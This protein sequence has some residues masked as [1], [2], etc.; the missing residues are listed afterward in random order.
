MTVKIVIDAGHG[1]NTPGKRTPDG[2]MREWEFNAAT[3]EHVKRL[4]SKYEGVQVLFTHD[5]TG[6]VDVSLKARTDKANRWGADAFVSIHANA[7]GSGTE[8]TNAHGIETYIHPNASATSKALAQKIQ[9]AMIRFTGRKDRGVR[10]ANFQVLRETKMPAVLVECGFMT[11]KEEA[12]LLKDEGYRA[13][14]ASAIVEALVAQ[15]K[16]KPKQAPAATKPTTTTKPTTPTKP[17]GN[18]LFK[19][20]VGAFANRDNA[21]R[22]KKELESKGYEVIIVEEVR[23]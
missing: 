19:V 23:K 5:P 10:T 3:A 9:G 22:L 1:Y 7:H 13:R 2:S 20:Q 16:L 21:E 8:W 18:T 14:C 4:L 6:K 15:F 11:N 12:K 17:T